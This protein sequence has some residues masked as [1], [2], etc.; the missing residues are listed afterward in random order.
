LPNKAKTDGIKNSKANVY[1]GLN[2]QTTAT[3][4]AK[5]LKEKGFFN[6]FSIR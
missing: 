1:N 2:E 5:T 3:T 4:T 6:N